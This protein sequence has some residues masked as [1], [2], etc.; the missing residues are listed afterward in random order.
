MIKGARKFPLLKVSDCRHTLPLTRAPAWEWAG[1]HVVSRD[2]YDMN[3]AHSAQG[4]GRSASTVAG[5]WRGIPGRLSFGPSCTMRTAASLHGTGSERTSHVSWIHQ[6]P[7]EEATGLL[8]SEY[9]KAIR[10]AGRLWHIVRIMSP[11]PRVLKISMEFYGAI[12]F[13]PSALSRVQR[14]L[15]GTVVSS[16]L[17]CHY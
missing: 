5:G 17:G 14:E 2:I 16:E 15:L 13:G 6:V 11:N 8:K 10:R 3:N 1:Q 12:M 9:D 4:R 7:V